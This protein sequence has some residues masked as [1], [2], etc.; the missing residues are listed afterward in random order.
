MTI[1]QRTLLEVIDE[2]VSTN[3]ER[4][5][6]RFFESSDALLKG[7]LRTVTYF[8]LDVAI[9]AL[10][11]WIRENLGDATGN[12]T[13]CYIGPSDIAYYL[14]AFAASK[15]GW[16]VGQAIIMN[17]SGRN[18]SKAHG[19]FC[20]RFSPLPEMTRVHMSR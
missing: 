15:C 20:R 1:G 5:W 13:F 14:L 7:E 18:S 9:N 16:K 10:S 6:L 11:W 12:P 17:C 2:V 19:P 3:T 4:I 8:D